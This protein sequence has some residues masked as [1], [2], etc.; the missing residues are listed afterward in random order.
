[1]QVLSKA[2]LGVELEQSIEKEQASRVSI[3]KA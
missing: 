1:M 2:R 3:P